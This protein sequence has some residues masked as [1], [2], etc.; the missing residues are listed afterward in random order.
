MNFWIGFQA[1]LMKYEFCDWFK[2]PG[3]MIIKHGACLTD[4]IIQQKTSI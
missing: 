2:R 1:G 3:L 4:I